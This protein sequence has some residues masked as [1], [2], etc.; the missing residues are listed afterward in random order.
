MSVG[1]ISMIVAAVWVAVVVI[2]IAICG[3][4]AHADAVSERLLTRAR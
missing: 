2:V 1:I 4:A 3:A